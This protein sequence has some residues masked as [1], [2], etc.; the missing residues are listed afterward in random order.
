M[1][2]K[3]G[4]SQSSNNLK[5]RQSYKTYQD[6][7]IVLKINLSSINAFLLVFFLLQFEN[8]LRG[9]E[10]SF[11]LIHTIETKEFVQVTMGNCINIY[12]LVGRYLYIYAQ[13]SFIKLSYCSRKLIDSGLHRSSYPTERQTSDFI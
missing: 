11:C 3:I 8:M 12:A 9:K 10:K 7:L 4:M 13:H 5:T 1:N 6:W 2:F